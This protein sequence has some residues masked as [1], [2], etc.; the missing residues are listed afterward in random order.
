MTCSTMG[1]VRRQLV[2]VSA[3][4]V[5]LSA[6]VLLVGAFAVNRLAAAPAP[7]DAYASGTAGALTIATPEAALPS[8][9]RAPEPRTHVTPPSTTVSYT[10][11]ASRPS[12]ASSAPA[13]APA[14]TAMGHHRT[15]KGRPRRRAH[16]PKEAPPA[17][18]S[19]AAAGSVPSTAPATPPAS[20]RNGKPSARPLPA[21]NAAPKLAG[22]RGHTKGDP[23]HGR[24]PVA[25]GPQAPT[26][27]P[28]GPKPGRALGRAQKPK[29]AHAGAPPAPAAEH[30]NG[31]APNGRGNGAAGSA[32]GKSR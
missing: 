20:R 19:V 4:S 2:A 15:R 23:P 3:L 26:Q 31:H 16:K 5:A 32:P 17:T 1:R 30:G 10:V 25:A 29:P 27:A 21:R 24:G 7:P 28:R 8:A 9:F 6:V 13:R 14:T 22:S 11:A 12:R 18:A